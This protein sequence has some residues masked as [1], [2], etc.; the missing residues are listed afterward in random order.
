MKPFRLNARMVGILFIIATVTGVMAAVMTGPIFDAPDYLIQTAANPGLI[1]LASFLYFV[2]AVSCAGIGL[3]LYP[4][5]RTYRE[6]LAIGVAGF[7]LI[8]GMI[9]VIG[10]VSMVCLLALSQAFIQAGSGDMIHFQTIGILLKAGSNWL[11]NGPMLLSW[12]IAALM[13]YTVF[14]QFN[15]VPRW[16]SVWGLVGI[17]ITLLVSVLG[18]LN[19]LPSFGTV[20]TV[21][22][23]PIAIQEMVFAVWLI[24]RGI[25]P[26]SIT[27]RVAMPN[28]PYGIE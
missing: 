23:L 18:M 4:I 14:Y 21:T 19:L 3:A 17:S 2:M 11:A 15:L 6:D 20:Q 1:T 28:K 16:L 10:G 8:E 5:V 13:Y 9:Q 25:Q 27:P 22:N 26:A 24:A 12:C 7:R